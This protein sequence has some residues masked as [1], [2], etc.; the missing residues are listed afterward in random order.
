M[1]SLENSSDTVDSGSSCKQDQFVHGSGNLHISGEYHPCDL[2]NRDCVTLD[3]EEKPTCAAENR[4][5]DS[6]LDPSAVIQPQSRHV[7]VSS[8]ESEFHWKT[9]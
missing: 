4:S 9:I 8:D 6:L 3:G 7:A 2:Q 1:Y 5:L